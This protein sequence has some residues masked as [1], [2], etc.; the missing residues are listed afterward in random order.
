MLK[1]TRFCCYMEAHKRNGCGQH[2]HSHTHNHKHTSMQKA[3]IK[4][5]G[6]RRADQAYAANVVWTQ[7]TL[8]LF[9]WGG[10]ALCIPFT[11]E[12]LFLSITKQTVMVATSVL[13]SCHRWG[14]IVRTIESIKWEKKKKRYEKPSGDLC[15]ATNYEANVINFGFPP[16]KYVS[17]VMIFTVFLLLREKKTNARNKMVHAKSCDLKS[18]F[19]ASR[20]TQQSVRIC[21]GNQHRGSK[22][23]SHLHF[24]IEFDAIV[25]NRHW[26]SHHCF[27]CEDYLLTKH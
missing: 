2:A 5:Y 7:N 4:V 25:Y 3:V 21:R 19:F 13:V 27:V 22:I 23:L 18:L 17:N 10:Y 24:A 11:E 26:F 16:T 14:L 15:L 9:G 20:F 12:T 8:R 1:T 6:H